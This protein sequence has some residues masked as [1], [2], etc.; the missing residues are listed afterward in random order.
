ML[1]RATLPTAGVTWFVAIS[2]LMVLF[3]A[4]MAGAQNLKW[5]DLKGWKQAQ[6]PQKSN[7]PIDTGTS[8]SQTESGKE[9]SGGSCILVLV[10]AL[11]ILAFLS[12]RTRCN[13]PTCGYNGYSWEFKNSR[14]PQCAS[15]Q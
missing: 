10:I 6:N 11:G 4:D 12:M 9:K 7:P 5:D 8:K 2:L 3:T 15:L 13:R 14:C 1:K